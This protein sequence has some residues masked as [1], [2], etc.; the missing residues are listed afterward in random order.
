MQRSDEKKLTLILLCWFF[1]LF[2]VHRHYTGKRLTG[3]LQLGALVLFGLFALLDVG[4][5]A[6]VFLVALFAWIIFDAALIVMGRFTDRDGRRI[7]Q[8]V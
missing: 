2:G 8:W 7:V 5:I 3:F 4:V 6:A 1:G